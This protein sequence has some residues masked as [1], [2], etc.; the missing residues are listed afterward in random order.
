MRCPR[1]ARRSR[2]S[3]RRQR[4]QPWR[5]V[6]SPSQCHSLARAVANMVRAFT[7]RPVVLCD[8]EQLPNRTAHLNTGYA[9]D[10]AEPSSLTVTRTRS[11]RSRCHLSS[12]RPTQ[13]RPRLEE[14]RLMPSFGPSEIKFCDAVGQVF[15]VLPR[16]TKTRYFS[17]GN[18]CR[19]FKA[20]YK[21]VSFF[22]IPSP[23]RTRIHRSW[24]I[25]V[26]LRIC[27]AQ[28]RRAGRGARGAQT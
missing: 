16:F 2:R 11:T 1:G 5:G 13:H 6:Q 24:G 14:E 21:P 12:S 27:A 26:Q 15:S 25:G 4:G 9:V 3:L 19:D 28:E 22:G 20:I 7:N 8:K 18:F 10:I 23:T 17:P